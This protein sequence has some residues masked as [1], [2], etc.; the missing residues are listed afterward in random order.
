MK[1]KQEIKQEIKRAQRRYLLGI[2]IGISLILASWCG[3]SLIDTVQEYERGEQDLKL[4]Y[5]V[6]EKLRAGTEDRTTGADGTGSREERKKEMGTADGEEYRKKNERLKVYQKLREKNNDLIGWIRIDGTSINYPVMQS[7]EDPDFYL[8]HGFGK[9]KSVY[10]MI[11]MD[12]GCRLDSGCRNYLIYGHHM[13]NG[14]MFAAL[15]KYGSEE[16]YKRY[17]FISFDTLEKT[18]IWEIF[19]VLRLSASELS[20]KTSILA[21]G[22]EKQYEELVEYAGSGSLYDT[23]IIPKWP[24]PLLTLATCEYST[25]DGRLLLLARKVR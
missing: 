24:E 2:V 5:E 16:R 4:V 13:K 7:P 3:Y 18:G 21:A 11:Y 22:T 10:G 15:E 19:A 14:S 6:M 20:E 9:E 23:G 17:P 8:T 25:K 12:A 1:E